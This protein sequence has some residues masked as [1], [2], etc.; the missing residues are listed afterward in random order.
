M[1]KT[2][3]RYVTSKRKNRSVPLSK[4]RY[5]C[6]STP[7]RQQTTPPCEATQW[8]AARRFRGAGGI[9]RRNQLSKDRLRFTLA[10]CRMGQK[11][12]A[13]GRG[14]EEH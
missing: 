13:P 5:R 14:L 2:G 11:G 4:H 6:R 7:A 10:Y 8:R 1:S 3:D 9:N 12:T